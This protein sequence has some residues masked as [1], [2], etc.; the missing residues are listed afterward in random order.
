MANRPA[1]RQKHVGG[2][3]NG[4]QTHGAGLGFSGPAGKSDGYSGRNDS[5]AGSGGGQRATRGKGGL[6][7]IIIAVIVL[8]AGGGGIGSLLGGNGGGDD[9]LA[10]TKPTS[11]QSTP[12]SAIP[13]SLSSL[14]GGFSG[15]ASYSNGWTAAAN[16]GKLNTA[17]AAGARAK[18]TQ[19]LGSGR[20]TVTLMV[21]MCGTDLES[22]SGMASADLREMAAATLSDKVNIIVY[23]GGC[24]QWK[25]SGISNT[26]NQI[27]K[28]ENGQM[29]LLVKDDGR[30][31]MTDPANLT[32]FIRYCT[33]NYPANRQCLIF[34]DHGGGT[35]SGYGY[36]EKNASAGSMTLAGIN[37]ALKNAGTTFDYIGFDACLMATLETALILDPYADYLIASEET[38]PGVGWYYTNWLTALSKNTSLPTVELG[39]QIVDDFVTVC[40]QKCRGQKTT[41]SVVDLAELSQTV[42]DKLGD[43]STSTAQLI[44]GSGYATVSQARN[45][46]REFAVS[47]KIDQI[48]L[49]HL[50]LNLD[51]AESKALAS[52]LLSA[53]KYNRTSS[54][55]TDAYGISAYF[56]Y[57]SSSKVNN[58]VRQ[59]ENIGMDA[60]Y[61]ACVKKFASLEVTGQAA[62]GGQSS[63]FGS[64]FGSLTGGGSSVGSVTDIV[65]SLLGGSTSSS[66]SSGLSTIGSLLGGFDFFDR[67]LNGENV[68][69]TVEDSLIDDN[70]LVWTEKNG[71]NVLALSEEE[72]ANVTDVQL[73]VFYDDGKG[74]IDLGLDNVFTFTEDGD[75]VG[76]YDGTWLAIDG[77]IVAYYFVDSFTEGDDYTVT[78]RVPCLLNDERAELILVFDNAHP[79]GFIAGARRVYADGETET[80]AKNETALNVGDVIQPI[81]DRY[82]YDGEWE[83]AYRLGDAFTYT[84]KNEIL[85]LYVNADYSKTNLIASYLLN[86][87]YCMEHWTSEIR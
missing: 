13:S 20:D 63:P 27:Y 60:D 16:T 7:G 56:P 43:F 5:G 59:L 2:A 48:D 19:I 67:S 77:N 71:K 85:N 35:I 46:T 79:D 83:D 74:Y 49:V 40:D 52:A 54:A 45:D 87:L 26:V 3:S 51:T 86:D 24:K 4:V 11:S 80:V 53:V 73:N 15:N 33:K 21:Y 72:W 22:K 23:T 75:L 18:R 38:E 39:K 76:E 12:S 47:S 44:S 82:T 78:G 37:T 34:W 14:F 64:L 57:R 9:V 36:D 17:V 29:R 32:R 68:I 6:I 28:I 81:C 58:A 42:P 10:T 41:L 8:L 31:A 50:A 55:V 69:S 84:G 25:L 66:S 30:S 1:G 65:G 61:T 62:Q 70:K